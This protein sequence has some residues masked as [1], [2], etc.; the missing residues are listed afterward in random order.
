MSATTLVITK[1]PT[2]A[3]G[4]VELCR[5]GDALVASDAL[6]ML[7]I[8]AGVTVKRHA[9]GHLITA[10]VDHELPH[11]VIVTELV[12]ELPDPWNRN[13]VQVA[14]EL[15]ELL[16]RLAATTSGDLVATPEGVRWL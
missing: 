16:E 9:L 15:R 10:D 7:G 3:D 14:D 5:I 8:D 12:A 6:A 1:G 11:G 4:L 13:H 2:L